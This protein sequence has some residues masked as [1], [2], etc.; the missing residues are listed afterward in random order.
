[1]K[2]NKYQT[3]MNRFI[4]HF[5]QT[6]MFPNSDSKWNNKLFEEDRK[7]LQELVEKETP[8][9]PDVSIYSDSYDEGDICRSFEYTVK[10][11]PKC[12]EDL[13]DECE[14]LDFSELPRCPFCGQALDWG[15]V[16]D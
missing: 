2:M 15:D 9:K 7:T 6:S 5:T 8:Q 12:K 1:M 4:G 16:C 14:G 13:Y 10:Q 3:A 11:C